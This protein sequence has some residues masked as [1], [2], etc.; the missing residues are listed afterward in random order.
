M[1]CC[2]LRAIYYL[3]KTWLSADDVPNNGWVDKTIQSSR[4]AFLKDLSTGAANPSSKGKRLIV[5]HIGLEEGF[6]PGGLLSFQPNKDTGDYH[7]EMNGETF[8]DWMK[9]VL[10]LLKDN[11]VLSSW[12][13]LLT[14]A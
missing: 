1:A 13:M 14:T 6:V 12:T 11:I 7:N 8:F 5:L 3:D 4:D 9:E 2:Y 10:P